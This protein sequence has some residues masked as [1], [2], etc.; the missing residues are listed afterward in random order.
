MFGEKHL[1]ISEWGSVGE[2]TTSRK[3]AVQFVSIVTRV[4]QS[5]FGYHLNK[6]FGNYRP[7][8]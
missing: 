7:A 6:G 3:E 1:G 8:V 2:P 4:I 5:S